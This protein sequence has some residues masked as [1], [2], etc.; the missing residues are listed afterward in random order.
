[1]KSERRVLV[2]TLVVLGAALFW[3]VGACGGDGES[4][5]VTQE[6]FWEGV[7]YDQNNPEGVVSGG[8]Q[9]GYGDAYD[10]PTDLPVL[11]FPEIIISTDQLTLHIFDRETGF[12]RVY[13]IGAGVL[14]SDGLCITPTGH[15][16]SGPDISEYWW[17]IP[18]RSVPEYFGGFPFIR[19]TAENSRGQNT[20]GIHG[21]ITESLIR[22]YVSHG[23]IRMEGLDVVEVFYLIRDHA[24]TPVTIQ[25]EPELDAAGEVVDLGTDVTL[26]E[27]GEDIV[28]GESVGDA[29]PRDNTG[30]DADGCAD[31]RLES[32]EAVLLEK[33]TYTGL[34]LCELDTDTY[35]IYL[36][37]GESMTA[38]ISF[39]HEVTDLDMVLVDPDDVVLD[40]SITTSNTEEVSVTADVAGEYKIS[41]YAY[42]EGE[43]TGY[44]LVIE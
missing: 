24:S 3:T 41:I 18:R 4:S 6:E 21:P 7:A 19:L 34:I 37:E 35:A 36:E 43:D 38:T 8:K 33:N 28:Y 16:A 26:W 11:E 29:P 2:R 12:S 25:R 17:Y 14:N 10:V 40:R 39:L 22:G 31:D 30:T 42:G 15:F 27:P 1:M 44:D 9:D 13:P 23:C 5:K 32:E 20:Y